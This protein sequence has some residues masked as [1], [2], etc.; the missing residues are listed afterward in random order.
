[1][2]RYLLVHVIYMYITITL[3]ITVAVEFTI[4]LNVSG[5]GVGSFVYR[6]RSLHTYVTY[7]DLNPPPLLSLG[8]PGSHSLKLTVR[9]PP[10]LALQ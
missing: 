10:V 5:V 7:Y 2:N 3:K 9:D 8:G 1:M 4:S 6:S